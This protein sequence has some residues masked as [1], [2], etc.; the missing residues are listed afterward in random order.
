M[1]IRLIAAFTLFASVAINNTDE[2][3][4]LRCGEK[5]ILGEPRCRQMYTR[6]SRS[7]G[8]TKRCPMLS[9][10]PCNLRRRA[11]MVVATMTLFA[12]AAC[13]GFP[14]VSVKGGSEEHWV[15]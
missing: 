14:S 1:L 13:A 10:S 3:V 2:A 7:C 11:L 9:I 6:K 15:E 8:V 12:F 5:L 4:K